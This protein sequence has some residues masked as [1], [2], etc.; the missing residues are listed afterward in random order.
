MYCQGNSY[1]H[2][3]MNRGHRTGFIADKLHYHLRYHNQNNSYRPL[4]VSSAIVQLANMPL[5]RGMGSQYMARCCNSS[6]L[7]EHPSG[8]LS[9]VKPRR[10][11]L[12]QD[13]A[14]SDSAVS[15]H[16]NGRGHVAASSYRMCTSLSFSYTTIK[17]V[18]LLGC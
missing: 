4:T 7:K 10:H 8:S 16:A 5:G 15:P 17:A 13:S 6:S 11:S 1:I 12:S 18:I 3:E 9:S 2:C 14:H